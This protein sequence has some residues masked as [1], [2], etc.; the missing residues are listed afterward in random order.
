MLL[1][2]SNKINK[3]CIKLGTALLGIQ[4]DWHKQCLVHKK[5]VTLNYA[6]FD[7]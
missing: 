2:T 5:H 4:A 6:G 1:K 3:P 7:V